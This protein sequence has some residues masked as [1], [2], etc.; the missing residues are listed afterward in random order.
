M[1]R[2]WPTYRFPPKFS[3]DITWLLPP[4]YKRH[5]PHVGL[6]GQLQCVH[7][8]RS[9]TLHPILCREASGR[10]LEVILRRNT[11][12]RYTF[13]GIACFDFEIFDYLPSLKFSRVVKIASRPFWSDHD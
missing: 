13:D 9:V 4:L 10:S 12:Q 2:G 3:E 8:L 6:T 11:Y 1:K 7:S 5:S